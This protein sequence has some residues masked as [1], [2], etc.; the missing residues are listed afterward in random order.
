MREL[1]RIIHFPL[2]NASIMNNTVDVEDVNCDN[3]QLF[4]KEDGC[5]VSRQPCYYTAVV[6]A[7]YKGNVQVCKQCPYFW[8]YTIIMCTINQLYI[9]SNH[10]CASF[11][12]VGHVMNTTG[13]DVLTTCGYYG[14]ILTVGESYI[15][16]IGGSCFR[17]SSWASFRSYTTNDIRLLES[18][19]DG[20]AQT[21]SSSSS[22][23]S[24]TS[25]A[26]S[27]NSISVS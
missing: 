3:I 5:A 21:C 8:Q 14:R 11:I 26:G 24:G 4:N 19:R 2:G 9:H 1:I 17:I 6:E 25:S 16:G 13:P 27:V 23:S 12:Q 18:L 20:G 10:N 7:V 22:S 15:V